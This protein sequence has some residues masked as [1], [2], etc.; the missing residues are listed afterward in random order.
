MSKLSDAISLGRR[1]RELDA[2]EKRQAIDEAERV[3][4]IYD[5]AAYERAVYRIK[6][7]EGHLI[8]GAITQAVK[9]GRTEH[10]FN[11]EDRQ[12]AKAINDTCDGVVATHSS[13]E[14]RDPEMPISWE[15]VTITW[16]IP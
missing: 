1:A 12:F 13:G 15:Q 6:E 11:D 7:R 9:D 14:S 3:Q 2:E 10:I 4:K 5:T 8:Y 16:K